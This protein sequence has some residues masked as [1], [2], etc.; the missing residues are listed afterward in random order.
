MKYLILTFCAGLA[1]ALFAAEPA[2]RLVHRPVPGLAT[3][4]APAPVMPR[5]PAAASVA[6]AAPSTGEGPERARILFIHRRAT[7]PPEMTR[8]LPA[9]QAAAPAPTPAAAAVQVRQPVI[10]IIPRAGAETPAA[11]RPASS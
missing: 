10:K 8:D 11:G 2:P 9:P 3:A 6:A 5:P 1:P 4:A 7:L